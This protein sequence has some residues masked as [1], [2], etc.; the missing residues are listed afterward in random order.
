MI[1]GLL[2][3][4]KGQ[5]IDSEDWGFVGEEEKVFIESVTK[6]LKK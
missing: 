2:R 3:F 6:K 1:L 5:I 4:E